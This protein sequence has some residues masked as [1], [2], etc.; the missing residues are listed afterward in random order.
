PPQGTPGGLVLQ[1][2]PTTREPSGLGT[3]LHELPIQPSVV[4]SL[5]DRPQE[6][7]DQ[8]LALVLLQQVRDPRVIA[9]VYLQ[10]LRVRGR[11]TAVGDGVGVSPALLLAAVGPLVDAKVAALDP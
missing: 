8:R 4:L 5:G 1:V 9:E 7:L 10:R 3:C 6:G 11:V 2:R